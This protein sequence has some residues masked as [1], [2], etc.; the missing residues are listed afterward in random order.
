VTAPTTSTRPSTDTQPPHLPAAE[1]ALLGVSVAVVF[2]FSRLFAD[3]GY[4]VP[5]LSTAVYAHLVALV[6]RRRGWSVGA[7]GAA[8][9]LGWIVL[10]TWTWFPSTTFVLLPT[11]A[12]WGAA[13]DALSASWT[14][15]QEIAAPV[16]SHT[17]FVLA[18]AFAVFVAAFLADWAAFRLWSP[19]EAVVPALTLFVFCSVL[20]SEQHRMGSALLFAISVLV[21]VLAQRVARLEGTAGWLTSDV[22]RGSGWLLR[23]GAALSVLAV[24]GGAFVGPRLP[25]ADDDALIGWR[26]DGGSGS[27]VVVSPLVEIRDRLVN[28]SNLE[29]FTVESEH[30]AYWRLTALD[31]FDGAI[32][33]SGGRYGEATGRLPASEPE[34]VQID[35]VEQTFE[36]GRLAA[37]WLP[38]AFQPVAV[39]SPDVG[40]RYQ[41]ESSTLIVD[42]RQ[43]TSDDVRYRVLSSIPRP[44][45]E[46]FGR[47]TLGP[48]AEMERYLE[49]PTDF[50]TFAADTAVRAVARAEADDPFATALALQDFFLGRGPFADDEF[51]FV[52]DLEGVG[53]GHSG[54][55]ID[56][57]LTSGR[58][59]CE[60]FAGTYAAMA[61]SVG[62]PARVAVGFTMGEPDPA[63]PDRYIVRGRHAHA[64]PEVW[65]GAD[66]GWIA[67]EPTPGR[68]APGMAYA[69]IAP[70][71][72]SD[73]EDPSTSTTATTT[74]PATDPPGSGAADD[75]S[76]EDLAGLLSQG[77]AGGSPPAGDQR[78]W[79]ERV[80]SAA[81][82]RV[83]PPALAGLGLVYLAIVPVLRFASR[84][85]RRRRA[86]DPG[87]RVQVAW[88]ESI[89]DLELVGV[90]RRPHETHDELAVR[91]GERLPSDARRLRMLAVDTDAATFSPEH[92][93]D[94]VAERSEETAARV[95]TM[96]R[97]RVPRRRLVLRQLDLRPL[98]RSKRPPRRAAQTSGR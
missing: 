68:G 30:A 79:I 63:D 77:D 9:L 88:L 95:G 71:Q 42:G 33:R 53:A 59:Y 50:S 54:S 44:L 78:S 67:F 28:Q 37:P 3:W 5:M 75:V 81:V 4:L 35:T 16:P 10:A 92:L 69:E 43:Q 87:A 21:F 27:R 8:S 93:D 25:G 90:V 13:G 2:G 80:T 83:G 22:E 38:A 72:V 49:L 55:A 61:R 23:T 11:L 65:L 24:L 51:E 26:V 34:A 57:F 62:L 17:G 84:R 45:P 39:D 36:M 70:A 19:I 89:E 20:G 96:V 41:A 15:F 31:I 97:A 1:A 76:A 86:D 85:R 14:A 98:V 46:S 56:D 18:G 6:L 12:T 66:V 52:Y 32:W 48:P 73:D 47:S 82:V 7:A 40:V 74:A 29:A 64:W 60:Q 91:A 58:G 94:S